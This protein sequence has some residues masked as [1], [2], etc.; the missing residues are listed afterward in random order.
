MK[1]II[2]AIII[3]ALLAIPVKAQE[4]TA[5]T[6]PGSAEK[7]MPRQ[8]SSFLSDFLYVI[9]SAL[10][11]LQPSFAEASRICLAVLVVVLLVSI[12]HS[13][14][15]GAKTVTVLTGTVAAGL[16][17]ITPT[18]TLIGMGVQ[19]VAEVNEYGK[20]LIPVITAALAA[21]GGVTSSTALYMV[22]T[23]FCT[24]LSSLIKVLIVPLI[25]IYLC[26]SVASCAL[27]EELL[28]KL[29]GTVKSLSS[30]IMRVILYLFTG[31]LTVTGVV[32]GSTDASALK[33][34]K[35]T[36]SGFVP[37]VGSILSDAS[38]AILVGTGLMKNAAG[39]YGVLAI[40]AIG[41]GPFL[42][43]GVQYVLVKITGG[44]CEIF[45]TKQ[46]SAL[47]QD[48]SGAMGLVLGMI[49]TECVMLLISTVCF[50]RGIA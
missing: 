26:L 23:V 16:L 2:T 43:I 22:T 14:S 13:V 31:F 7:Y 48:F 21:Q 47:V 9:K 24:V 12:V 20:M 34:A 8:S 32:S 10:T 35:L 50:M 17:L 42:R 27:G 1:R 29:K 44:L 11:E 30:W 49:G 38:E 19:T 5:P 18:S 41:I 45:D 33:A 36:I 37:V 46:I 6:V 4:F 15:S 40:V 28:L 39:V 3:I 25:Y